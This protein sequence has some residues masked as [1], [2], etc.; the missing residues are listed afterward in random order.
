MRGNR[1]KPQGVSSQ[2]IHYHS[3]NS[4]GQRGLP[5]Q[6]V[7]AELY[8]MPNGSQNYFWDFDAVR[9]KQGQISPLGWK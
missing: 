6:I 3:G 7:S 9:S 5:S 4:I 8:F 2:G 1:K